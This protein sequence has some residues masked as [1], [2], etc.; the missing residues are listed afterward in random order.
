M[1]AERCTQKACTLKAEPCGAAAACRSRCRARLR[2]SSSRASCWFRGLPDWSAPITGSLLG[3]AGLPA[4]APVTV[5]G[6]ADHI[7]KI[8]ARAG[9]HLISQ[10]FT[11]FAAGGLP[12]CTA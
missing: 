7:S 12:P 3:C 2:S 4:R 9:R 1:H 5:A 6:R 8:E 11:R 10:N